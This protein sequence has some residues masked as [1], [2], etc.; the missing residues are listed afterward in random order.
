MFHMVSNIFLKTEGLYDAKPAYAVIL[1]I[2]NLDTSIVTSA[3]FD[4]IIWV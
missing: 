1:E 2:V 3:E 4:P